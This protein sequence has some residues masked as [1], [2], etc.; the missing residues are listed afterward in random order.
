VSTAA[1]ESTRPDRRGHR[2]RDRSDLLNPILVK[3]LRQGIRGTLFTG[4]FLLLHVLMLSAGGFSLA[5][6]NEGPARSAADGLFWFLVTIPVLVILPL[7][8]GASMAGEKTA[9]TLEPVLLTRLTARQIVVGKWAS[10][11]LQAA[12]LISSILPYVVL[13]Y[14]LGSVDVIPEVLGL[15]NL[16]VSCLILTAIAVGLGALRSS[17]LVRWL[18][19]LAFGGYLLTQLQS[20][21][22][23]WSPW[24]PLGFRGR[25]QTFLIAAALGLI[26]TIVL[27]FLEVGALM[28][29]PPAE[30]RSH[31]IRLLALVALLLGACV[32]EGGGSTVVIG[33]FETV[34]LSWSLIVVTGVAITVACEDVK[35]IPGLY[36]PFFR[37]TGLRRYFRAFLTPGW[38]SGVWLTSLFLAGVAFIFWPRVAAGQRVPFFVA[39]VGTVFLPLAVVRV[40]L[41]SRFK[42]LPTYLL[43]H[44]LSGIPAVVY[45]L[46]QLSD[47]KTLSAVGV[48]TA[49]VA[50][51]SALILG[52]L[53]AWTLYV[54]ATLAV[55]SVVAVSAEAGRVFWQIRARVASLD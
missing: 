6:A 41:R 12:L 26:G 20:F 51:L 35:D 17:A 25:W 3:E 30:A 23:F 18:L 22:L 15:L 5:T 44:A 24:S 53:P 54:L 50:P 28:L 37:R 52:D 9:H 13:R 19:L 39:L 27:L 7:S 14:F 21:L 34:L 11:A 1:L 2:D 48:A 29:A 10:V 31:R 38:P 49:S 33:R 43:I 55:L 42:T 32:S 45:G 36:A 4:A 16:W 8:G 40:L 47:D 46:G